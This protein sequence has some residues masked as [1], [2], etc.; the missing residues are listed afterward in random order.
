MTGKFQKILPSYMI[1]LKNYIKPL[2]F[3]GGNYKD[4]SKKLK[5]SELA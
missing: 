2:Q 5:W 4:E 1:L 3:K